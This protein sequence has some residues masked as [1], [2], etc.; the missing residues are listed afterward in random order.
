MGMHPSDHDAVLS[1]AQKDH[2][3]NSTARAKRVRKAKQRL[4]REGV[5]EKE[6]ARQR[7]DAHDQAFLVPVPMYWVPVAGC[8]AYPYY[9]TGTTV[10]RRFVS[11]MVKCRVVDGSC[12]E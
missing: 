4:A 5:N 2:S 9:V 8:V 11:C 1:S 7:A 3:A 10:C 12:F 6:R